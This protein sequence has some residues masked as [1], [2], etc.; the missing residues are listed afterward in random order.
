MADCGSFC[1]AAV[2]A[3]RHLT[4]AIIA[5]TAMPCLKLDRHRHHQSAHRHT[6]NCQKTDARSRATGRRRRQ[7]GLHR[8]RASAL[9]K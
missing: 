6:A 7:D 8:G 4:W 2:S 9:G 1:H 5:E 3:Y